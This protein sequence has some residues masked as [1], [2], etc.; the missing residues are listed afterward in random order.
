MLALSLTLVGF[1]SG[2]YYTIVTKF[3]VSKPTVLESLERENEII[4]KQIEKRELLS[5][6]ESFEKN[7][8]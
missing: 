4:R 6:L 5:K 8:E 1:A 2:I 3:G 7:D